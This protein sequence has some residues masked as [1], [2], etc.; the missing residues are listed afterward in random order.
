MAKPHT[1]FAIWDSFESQMSMGFC[2]A[3]AVR[4]TQQYSD[5]GTCNSNILILILFHILAKTPLLNETKSILNPILIPSGLQS[6][7]V[8]QVEWEKSSIQELDVTATDLS[9]ECLI[10]MLTRTQNLRFLSAG[11]INGFND[12]VLKAWI[13]AGTARYDF[14]GTCVIS[15]CHAYYWKLLSGSGPR[16]GEQ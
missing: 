16:S 5:H 7:H 1:N 3:K 12:S 2:L 10:D 9:T 14:D 11:Q 13:E 4:L 15:L 8:M 6:E